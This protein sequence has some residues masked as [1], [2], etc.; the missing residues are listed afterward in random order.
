MRH[1]GLL[2]RASCGDQGGGDGGGA[3]APAANRRSPLSPQGRVSCT[4]RLMVQAVN[5]RGRSPRSPAGQPHGRRYR[6]RPF[7]RAAALSL[8][9]YPSAASIAGTG[10]GHGRKRVCLLCSWGWGG[11]RTGWARRP[12]PRAASGR[13]REPPRATAT[14]PRTRWSVAP[15]LQPRL[16]RQ[17]HAGCPLGFLRSARVRRSLLRSLRSQARLRP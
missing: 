5:Q 14:S 16:P 11:G 3:G 6:T 4:G 2:G 9:L 13:G 10:W 7:P 15:G 1:G 17:H 12:P 8:S